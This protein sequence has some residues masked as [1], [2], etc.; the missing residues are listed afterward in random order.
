MFEYRNFAPTLVVHEQLTR[1]V[2]TQTVGPINQGDPNPIWDHMLTLITRGY[3]TVKFEGSQAF[4]QSQNGDDFKYVRAPLVAT[5]CGV[6][7]N[8]YQQEFLNLPMW[9]NVPDAML[10]DQ[11]PAFMTNAAILDAEGN[12]TGLRKKWWDV[13]APEE[14]WSSSPAIPDGVGGNLVELNGGGR[15]EPGST[16]ARLVNAGATVL[17]LEQAVALIPPIP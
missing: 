14:S 5:V 16:V 8:Q 10:L 2:F 17:S 3:A 15:I 7:A 12:P 11:V 13:A 4:I 9:L 6:Q 1:A